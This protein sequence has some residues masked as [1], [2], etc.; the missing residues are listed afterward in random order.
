MLSRLLT[1]KEQAVLVAVAGSVCVGAIV[2]YVHGLRTSS[3]PEAQATILPVH[4]TVQPLDA[5]PVNRA[6]AAPAPAAPEAAPVPEELPVPI[7]VAVEGAIAQPG[8]YRMFPEA[9]LQDL[10][11]M[12][13]GATEAADLSDLN[14]AALLLDGTTVNVPFRPVARMEGEAMVLRRS[15][16]AAELNLAA[17]TVSGSQPMSRQPSTVSAAP[18]PTGFRTGDAEGGPLDL[19]RATEEQL[20]GLPGIGT[21]LAGRIVTYRAHTPFQSVEDLTNVSGIGDKKLEAVRPLVTVQP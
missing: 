2:L 21:E 17:Y 3:V 6:P 7:V 11:D 4:A 1:R 8:V 9:R 15:P 10:I 13:G 18:S 16:S 19:N 12:A 20:C 14:R 5:A